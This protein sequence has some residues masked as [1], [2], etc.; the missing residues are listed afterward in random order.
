MI[1]EGGVVVRCEKIKGKKKK[2]VCDVKFEMSKEGGGGPA[3]PKHESHLDKQTILQAAFVLGHGKKKKKT[4]QPRPVVASAL[5]WNSQ[6]PT[7]G[8]RLARPNLPQV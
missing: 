7:L 6:G 3:A 1:E 5:S 2:V 8:R 4:L